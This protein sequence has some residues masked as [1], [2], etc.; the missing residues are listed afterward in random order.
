M[1]PNTNDT[2]PTEPQA[3][4]VTPN[5]N[6]TLLFTWQRP[7]VKPS[8]TVY[9]L[10][11]STASADASVG[12]VFWSGEA[13]RAELVTPYNPRWYYVRAVTNSNV[14]PYEPNTFGI[15]GMPIWNRDPDNSDPLFSDGDFNLSTATT[16]YWAA[17]VGTTANGL[18]GFLFEA[19]TGFTPG[20]ASFVL[21]SNDL[22]G[23]ISLSPRTINKSAVNF[24]RELRVSLTYCRETSSAA[25]FHADI[26]AIFRANKAGGSSA[27]FLTNTT[28]FVS[29]LAVG[30][31]RTEV[32]S[33]SMPNSEVN[34]MTA[35]LIWDVNSHGAIAGE[36]T[37]IGRFQVFMS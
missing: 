7:I 32:W 26:R 1:L 5:V 15:H 16:S 4:A 9:Q 35:S 10:I 2:R 11:M 27:F 8:G 34:D 37:R 19:N 17:T 28:V 23:N 29:S 20:R 3:F 33:V 22:V 14:S 13:E 18:H 24:Q 6:G 36:R 21:D 12:S 25:N 31:W 30:E